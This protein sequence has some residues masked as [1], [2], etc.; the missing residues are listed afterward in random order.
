MKFQSLFFLFFISTSY[1]QVHLSNFDLESWNGNDPVDWYYDFGHGAGMQYGTLN[2][3]QDLGE[4]LSTFVETDQAAGGTG[5]SAKL[6]SVLTQGQLVN[7]NVPAI[8]GHIMKWTAY[9][10]KPTMMTFDYWAKPIGED[11][12][13]VYAEFYDLDTVLVGKGEVY[14]TEET[15]AWQKYYLP[16]DWFEGEVAYMHITCVSSVLPENIQENSILYVDNFELINTLIVESIEKSALLIFPNPTENQLTVSNIGACTKL[17]CF[18]ISGKLIFEQDVNEQELILDVTSLKGG[19]YI[20]EFTFEGKKE[21]RFFQKN[22][23]M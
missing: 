7:Q 3:F 21:R 17:T 12:A 1:S 16:I 13:A 22:S 18:D 20:L 11:F 2:W 23:R 5:S 6:I 10:E 14:F 4:P 8:P 15:S 9:T 19:K